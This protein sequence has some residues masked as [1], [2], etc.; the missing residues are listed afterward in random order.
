VIGVFGTVVTVGRLFELDASQLANA[1]GIAGSFSSG[2]ME[3]S[4]TGGMVKR[5]HL[6]RAAEGGFM[7]AVLARDGYTGPT[8]V[9]EGKFGIYN[10]F[11][12]DAETAR[13]T[14]DLGSVWRVMRTKIKRFACH[15]TAQV[16][17][18]LVLDLKEKHRISGDDV[19]QITIAANARTVRQHSVAE[20]KDVA[21]AQYSVQFCAALGLYLDPADPRAFSQTSLNDP[22][23]RALTREAQVGR[24]EGGGSDVSPACRVTLRLKDGREVSAEGDNFKGTPTMPLTRSELWEKFRKLTAHRDKQKA[25]RLFMQLAEAEKVEDFSALDFAM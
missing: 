2:L 16:P 1:F 22:R 14:M 25:E 8:G 21:M 20:P 15:A 13:L 12:R 7:A 4:L 23:I 10:V 11:C 17:V 9:L 5:L 18:T 6:G 3:F 24:L 19:A